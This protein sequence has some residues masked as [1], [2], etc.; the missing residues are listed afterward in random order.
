[1]FVS[2]VALHVWEKTML[3]NTI[4]VGPYMI[5]CIY[6]SYAADCNQKSVQAVVWRKSFRQKI[7]FANFVGNHS[8]LGGS[9]GGGA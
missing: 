8:N 7:G 5:V 6:G 2:A 1:M 9:V 4:G 3:D